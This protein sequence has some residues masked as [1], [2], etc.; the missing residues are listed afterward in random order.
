[1][2]C[3][4]AGTLAPSM[5][6]T[7]KSPVSVVV[8][9]FNTIEKLKR[10]LGCI[11]KL[12]EVIVVDNASLDGS[13][14]MVAKEFPEVRLV[15]NTDNVGFGVA[16][17]Q[18]SDLSTRDLILFLNSDAYADPG[19]IS[20]LARV[21]DDLKVVA[22]GGMLLNP[23]RT[24]QESVAGKLSLWAVFLEQ[25]FLDAAARK[26]GLGYWQTDRLLQSLDESGQHGVDQVM[27][28]CLM[29]RKGLEAFDPRFFLYCEDTDLCL[30]LRRHGEIVFTTRAQFV[31]DLGSS[32]A[33][34]PALGIIR[35]NRGKEL[36][37][38]IHQGKL[39]SML[40][41]ALDK[42]GAFLRLLAWSIISIVRPSKR[43]K[44]GI[45]WRVLRG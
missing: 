37:F 13:P 16:N 38:L 44:V 45:F 19:A 22:A 1:M 35:Y 6:S 41:K 34:D 17:N 28:A 9:S 40:C 10:C 26:V 27:G 24:L 36:F 42:M 18:G 7:D 39:A 25:F 33:K 20:E 14:E 11:E 23:D 43:S 30:R 32:S 8:V 5:M 15:R 21:F 31:H 2:D 29:V 3:F 12:H 4:E